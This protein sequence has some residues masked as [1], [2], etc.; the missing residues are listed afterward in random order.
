IT[1]LAVSH[2][3]SEVLSTVVGTMLRVIHGTLFWAADLDVSG[4]HHPLLVILEEAHRFLPEGG[5]TP[6]HRVLGR[7]AKEGRKYGVGLML[8]TQRPTEIDTS[9]LSQSGTLIALRTTNRA[10]RDKVAAALSDD[11]GGLV[12]LLP[13]LRTGEGLFVGEA[14]VVPSRVRIRKA[15]IKPVGGDPALP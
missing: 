12:D 7:I 3:P 1:I 11:L 13:A 2:V 4:R 8:V 15:L 14:V 5:E 9:V 10:D 6:A